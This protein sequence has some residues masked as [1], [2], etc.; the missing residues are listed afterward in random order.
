MTWNYRILKHTQPDQ[1]LFGIHEV[2]YDP[3]GSV[4][5]WTKEPITELHESVDSLI[6]DLENLLSDA[7]KFK[8]SVLD[9]GNS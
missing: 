1:I 5:G 6:S 7:K 3:N 9:S 8:D 4:V 2:F